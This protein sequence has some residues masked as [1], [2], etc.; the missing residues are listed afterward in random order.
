M[1]KTVTR[2]LWWCFLWM[3]KTLCKN[4]SEMW[5]CDLSYPTA[6]PRVKKT[7]TRPKTK[8]VR[9]GAT[10]NTGRGGGGGGWLAC[11]E[12]CGCYSDQSLRPSL[13]RD[14]I[15]RMFLHST[16][17][18]KHFLRIKGVAKHVRAHQRR[19]NLCPIDKTGLC[20]VFN[21]YSTRSKEWKVNK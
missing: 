12:R 18:T 5:D 9:V 13:F 7:G 21:N 11:L 8:G 16:W 4:W 20:Q 10:Q 17:Y 19:R 14:Y 15:L 2:A 3:S 6:P 1:R